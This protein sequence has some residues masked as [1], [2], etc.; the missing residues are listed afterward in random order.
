MNQRFGNQTAHSGG[1]QTS[2][3]VMSTFFIHSFIQQMI[4]K[5]LLYAQ[6]YACP[7]DDEWTP[8]RPGMNKLQP[9]GREITI[10]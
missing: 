7:A 3:L 6:P 1:R 9:R 8:I 10:T 4:I 2:I 5:C